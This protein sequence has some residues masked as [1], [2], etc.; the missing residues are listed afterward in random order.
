MDKMECPRCDDAFEPRSKIVNC[1]GELF[2]PRC[3]V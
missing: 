1:N 2:H 3:F